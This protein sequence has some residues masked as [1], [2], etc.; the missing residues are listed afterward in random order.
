VRARFADPAHA[1]SIDGVR[2]CQS[3]PEARIELSARLDRERIA[4]LRFLAWGCPH[5]IAACDFACERLEGG[6]VARLNDVDA[7]SIIEKLAVPIE[8]TGRI[9]LLEDALADL[10]SALERMD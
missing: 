4:E 6:P 9:L 2:V 1:G 10:R 5:L 3:G 8:K 7:A